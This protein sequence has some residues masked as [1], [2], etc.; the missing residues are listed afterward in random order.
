M[1]SPTGRSRSKVVREPL[2]VARRLATF[3]SSAQSSSK[4]G[5]VQVQCTASGQEHERVKNSEPSHKSAREAAKGERKEREKASIGA[6]TKYTRV[7]PA[8]PPRV[9]GPP[10]PLSTRHSNLL[11]RVLAPS[12]GSTWRPPFTSTRQSLMLRLA[13]SRAGAALGP[14]TAR[15]KAWWAA[16]G[17]RSGAA[18]GR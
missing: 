13:K 5:Q 17:P 8:A 1:G 15:G 11:C 7:L 3:T 4:P 12:R 6:D 9:S 14:R 16:E 18:S 10:R 2:L